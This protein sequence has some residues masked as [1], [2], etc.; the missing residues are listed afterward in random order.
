M[1]DFNTQSV[2]A[3]CD[4]KFNWEK[5]NFRFRFRKIE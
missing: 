4:V 3:D 2:F 5:V 1:G